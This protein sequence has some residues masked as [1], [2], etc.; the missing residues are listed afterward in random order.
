MIYFTGLSALIALIG[1][2]AAA[3][4]QDPVLSTFGLA[5]FGFGVLFGL[6]LV[7]QH[8]DARDAARH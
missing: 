5:L 3:A 1:L 4:A 2:A 8:F 7:K 6:F